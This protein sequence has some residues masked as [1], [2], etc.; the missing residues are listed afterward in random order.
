MENTDYTKSYYKIREVAD[1]VE[2]SASTLRY[3]ES[4]FPD[5][6]TPIRNPGKIRYYSP[7]VI[8]KIKLIK[9]LVRERGMKIEA[10]KE[11]LRRNHNNLSRRMQI[12]STLEEVRQSLISLKSALMK[13]H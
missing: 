6:I 8:E 9:Y 7:D 11:E 3:W 5:L 13:R 12:I 2:E 1:F 4:E 10:A